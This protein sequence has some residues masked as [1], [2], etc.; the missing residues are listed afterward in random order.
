MPRAILHHA[1]A[2]TQMNA[3]PVVKLEE[4]FASN[5]DDVIDGVRRVHARRVRLEV[6]RPSRGLLSQLF[7]YSSGH[8]S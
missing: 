6:V 1:V 2:L 7:D 3:L 8:M 4:D 5:H